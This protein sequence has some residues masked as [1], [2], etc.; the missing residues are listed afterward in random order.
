M[1][2]KL[3]RSLVG[4]ASFA[5]VV[6]AC[7][8]DDDNDQADPT[9]VLADYEDARNAGDVDAVMALYADDAVVTGHPLDAGDGA[10]NGVDEIRALEDLVPDIQRAEDA[11]EFIN[12]ETSGNS[13]TFDMRFFPAGS[14]CT[15]S[16]DHEVTVTDGLI[17][18]Y[19][20]GT[21]DEPCQ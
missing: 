12:I 8:D 11:A 3:R 10:A 18:F 17:T 15:G 5:L 16:S 13:V 2:N 14:S 9:A 19:A 21:V 7:S 1:S 4:F 20:W 6:A